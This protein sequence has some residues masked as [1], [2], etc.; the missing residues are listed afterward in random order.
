MTGAVERPGSIEGAIRV[1]AE[2]LHVLQVRLKSIEGQIERIFSRS[3]AE[4]TSDEIAS[5]QDIDHIVQSLDA[6]HGYFA[7]LSDETVECLAIRIPGAIETI[8]IGALRDRLRG[9]GE[10][11]VSRGQPELF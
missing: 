3:H 1:G 4:L 7:C 10:T 9:V 6:L 5:L 2:E 11:E 8:P